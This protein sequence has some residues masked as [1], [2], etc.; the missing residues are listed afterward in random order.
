[1]N[2][3]KPVVLTLVLFC[4]LLASGQKNTCIGGL[5]GGYP[6]SNVDLMSILTPDELLAEEERGLFLN[7][8]WGWT[9]AKSGKEYVIVG[10]ANG[11]S[12]VDISDPIN[13]RMLGILPEHHSAESGRH[14]KSVWRDIKVY[15]DHAFIVS[16]EN[17]HGMQIFDLT[18]L[19]DVQNPPEIF[20]ET[21]H[22]AG[23]GAAHN[24]VINEETGYAYA[25]G[26]RNG[27]SV[28]AT[29]GGLH[30]I[31]IQDPTN[32]VYEACFDEDGYT[33]DAQ[34]VIY[35]G[36]DENYKGKEICFNSNENT[37]TIVDVNDKGDMQL[38]SRTGYDGVA[39]AHQ[40]WLTE[41]HNYF[42]SNDEA[43]ELDRITPFTKTFIWDVR[44]LD[45]PLLIGA[46]EHSTTSIDHNLY[47][48]DGQVF[49]SNYTSGLRILDV[50]DISNAKLSEIGYF[51]T[52]PQNDDPKFEGT[53]S[54]Y[55]F[56]ESGVVAV[57]DI[58]SGL[59][60]VKPRYEPVL[61]LEEYPLE[62]NLIYPVPVHDVIN[63]RSQES[64]NFER[65][66]IYSLA[67]KSVLRARIS[68]GNNAIDVSEIKRG[69]YLAEFT[70]KANEKLIQRIRID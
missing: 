14:D 66:E 62:K 51:D 49:E 2:S 32:P 42:L 43:D 65:L 34:C 12:F 11:T 58:A 63:I 54:N 8:I 22:Y 17:M 3:V 19:R 6:C 24:I 44:D 18:N 23:I 35:N 9:D 46:Y 7:D 59:F 69:M 56:F 37:I 53:W 13:P 40:G 45:A 67:G 27:P 4:A 21:G 30:V 55:P 36:F 15:K 28:C 47:I 60:L 39:Y 1:M 26:S 68:K 38:I 52:Y 16:D 50:S 20:A 29:I 5:A 64:T 61:G 57:S 48:T 70:G 41:D 33:H 25:V 31:N 10:M